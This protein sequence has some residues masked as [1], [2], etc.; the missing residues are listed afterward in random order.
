M[1]YECF[2]SVDKVGGTLMYCDT[3]SVFASFNSSPFGMKIGQFE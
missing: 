1:L 2:E 3:D